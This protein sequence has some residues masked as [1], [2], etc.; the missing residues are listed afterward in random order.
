MIAEVNTYG[1][2]DRM[3]MA[4]AFAWAAVLEVAWM[5]VNNKKAKVTW[6]SIDTKQPRCYSHE[7]HSRE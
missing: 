4:F 3:D 6:Y 5:L 7:S 1:G 2:V